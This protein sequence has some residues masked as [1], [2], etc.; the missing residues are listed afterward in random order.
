[1]DHRVTAEAQ[2]GPPF[3]EVAPTRGLGNEM[4]ATILLPSAG[5]GH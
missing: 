5:L 3:P 2:T 1:M 4:G